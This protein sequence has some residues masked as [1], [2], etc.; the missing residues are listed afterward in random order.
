MPTDAL[1]DPCTG[2]STGVHRPGVERSYLGLLVLGVVVPFS[3]VLPWVGGTD[4][5]C[6]GSAGSCSAHGSGALAGSSVGLPLRL[7]LR[8]RNLRVGGA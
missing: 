2:A 1:G 6:G 4:R 8:E 5:T 3:R 7:W